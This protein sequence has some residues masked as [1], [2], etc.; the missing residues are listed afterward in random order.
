LGRRADLEEA[1]DALV[2]IAEVVAPDPAW[3]AVYARMQPV[4]DRI[5][6][7]SQSLYDALDAIAS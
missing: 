5:Y 3:S 7:Q 2:A 1:V 4:F 6:R